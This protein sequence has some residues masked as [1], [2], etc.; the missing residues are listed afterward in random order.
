MEMDEQSPSQKLLFLSDVH[1]GGFSEDKNRQIERELI[2]LIDFCEANDV[3]I[4]VLGDLF[5]YWM[6]Y[7]GPGRKRHPDLGREL[8]E[9]FRTYNARFG[10][11]LYITGNHDNWTRDY[12]AGIGFTV[13]RDYR[14]VTVNGKRVLLLHGDGTIGPE[15][16]VH[17]PLMHRLLRNAQFVR[18]FQ[19][20]F[21]PK[22]GWY[23]MRKFSELNRY[24]GEH[25]NTDLTPLNR[26]AEKKLKESD[27][28]I[29]LCGHDHVSRVFEFPFGTYINIGNFYK[30]RSVAVYNKNG[31]KLVLWDDANR[32]LEKPRNAEAVGR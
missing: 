10:P 30:D 3:K 1:L 15:G 25:G 9:R 32:K 29:I 4:Y 27:T 23:I 14:I 17:R 5:D 12:F 2:H 11:T 20:L 6:E 18:A 21:P 13:E 8:R 26:W 24:L 19:T 16:S 22:A 31:F 7:P 28:D